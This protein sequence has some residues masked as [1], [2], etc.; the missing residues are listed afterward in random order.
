RSEHNLGLVERELGNLDGAAEHA[1][2]AVNAASRAGDDALLGLVLHGQAETALRRGESEHARQL[3]AAARAV[4]ERSDDALGLAEAA[5]LEAMLAYAAGRYTAALNGAATAYQAAVRL[6]ARYL[7][8]ECALL[9]AQACNRL[10]RRRV[11]DR[12]RRRAESLFREV[13]AST[14]LRRVEMTLAR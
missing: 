11:S 8:G 13:G 5:R 9:A 6:G 3:L 10:S 12:F 4:A 1:A 2:R 14:A 7:A